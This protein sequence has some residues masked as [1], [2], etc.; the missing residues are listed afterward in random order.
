[1]KIA[2]KRKPILWMAGDSTMQSYAEDQRP[3]WGW[4]ECLLEILESKFVEMARQELAEAGV[5]NSPKEPYVP[6]I[7][8]FHREDCAFPQEKR[9]VGSFFELDN[10]A[11]AGRSSKTFREEGRLQDIA[12]HIQKGDYLIIQFGHNDAGKSKPE[13]YVALEDF[14]ASLEHFVEVALSH[15]AKPVFISSIVLCPGPQITGEAEEISRLLPEYGGVMRRYAEELGSPFID[16]NRLTEE[17]LAGKTTEEMESL[18]KPDHVHLVYDGA[19]AYAEL[20]AEELKYFL[21]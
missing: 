9:Y 7:N 3:Q 15:G 19:R 18:Y 4:G 14:K 5:V 16:M 20:V 10:C 8:S 2:K 11:M 1:M 6:T 21:R 17:F 13:R 12:G